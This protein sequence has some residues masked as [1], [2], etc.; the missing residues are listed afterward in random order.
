M[1]FYSPIIMKTPFLRDSFLSTYPIFVD[2]ATG[3]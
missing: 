2:H 1:I 3:S